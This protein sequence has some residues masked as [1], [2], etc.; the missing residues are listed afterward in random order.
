ML[1]LRCVSILQ[2]IYVHIKHNKKLQLKKSRKQLFIHL[3]YQGSFQNLL[4]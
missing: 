2:V 3:C 4:C 1:D